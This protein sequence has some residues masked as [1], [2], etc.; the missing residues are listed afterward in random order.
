MV[1]EQVGERRIHRPLPFHPAHPRE[2]LGLHLHREMA[3]AAAVV[4][5]MAAVAGAV[6]GHD[7]TCG[8]EGG[9]QPLLDFRGDSAGERLGHRAYIGRLAAKVSEWRA[10]AAGRGGFTDGRKRA[11][12][13]RI[14]A[15]RP[16]ASSARPPAAARASTARATGAGSASTMSASSTPATIISRG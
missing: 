3:L 4:A 7:E 6:V 14:P 8:L 16:R 1:A 12:P 2:S 10:R 15:A 5:G 11:A 9:A 13:A